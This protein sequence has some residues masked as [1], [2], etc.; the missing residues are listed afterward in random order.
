MIATPAMI[1]MV[2]STVPT[3]A[4]TVASLRAEPPSDD[5][6]HQRQRTRGAGDFWPWPTPLQSS[7]VNAGEVISGRFELEAVA[8]AG[9]CRITW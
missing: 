8:G 1:L 7:V 5:P 3:L 6:I 2:R 9:G 4:S